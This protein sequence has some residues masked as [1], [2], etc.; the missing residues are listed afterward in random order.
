M[1]GLWFK[2]VEQEM[3][4]RGLYEEYQR[5]FPQ[6]KFRTLR[7]YPTSEY[8]VRTS[9]AGSLVTSPETVHEGMYEMNRKNATRFASTI[10]GRTMIRLLDPHP[11][12]VVQQGIAAV[13]Q[14]VAHTQWRLGD[15]GPGYLEVLF[16]HEYMWI[17]SLVAGSTKGTFEAIN[18]D[19]EVVAELDDPFN[20]KVVCTWTPKS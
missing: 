15:T 5:Y 9:L 10:V 20:G 1:R 19:A 18:L 2:V 8:L 12:R 6:D 4:A 11:V 13:R 16:N 14:T 3:K 7:Y 17:E